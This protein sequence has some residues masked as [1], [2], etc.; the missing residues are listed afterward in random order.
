MALAN[1]F[2]YLT[3]SDSDVTEFLPTITSFL[4]D[5]ETG[6]LT[7][8]INQAL[9]QLFDDLKNQ[10]RNIKTDSEIAELRE[11]ELS[12]PIQRKIC[13]QVIANV[14]F[15]HNHADQ[16]QLYQSKSDSILLTDLAFS[17]DATITDS[18]KTGEPLVQ[19]GFSR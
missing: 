9:C 15:N 1:P 19:I 2:T 3:I 12:K 10:Y 18:E 4:S 11:F 7:H 14:M 8:E 16:A 6:G 5:E 17:A 13:Y